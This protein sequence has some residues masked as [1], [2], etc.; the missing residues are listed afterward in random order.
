M[1]Q[2]EEIQKLTD[3]MV[4]KASELN[5]ASSKMVYNIS[6]EVDND[7]KELEEEELS[8]CCGAGT[9]DEYKICESCGEH[10]G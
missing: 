9:Y 3:D 6:N 7:I 2:M 8:E 5:E 10:T 1:E 4:K